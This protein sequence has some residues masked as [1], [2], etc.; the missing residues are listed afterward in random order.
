MA[1]W[2]HSVGLVQHGLQGDSPECRISGRRHAD[3][4][5]RFPLR[6][7]YP[8]ANRTGPVMGWISRRVAGFLTFVVVSGILGGYAA[9]RGWISGE[10][11]LT[12]AAGAVILG[13]AFLT[14]LAVTSHMKRSDEARKAW[15]EN[16]RAWHE[17]YARMY[18]GYVRRR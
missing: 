16:Q 17:Y 14:S 15:E 10:P 9:V 12:T 4:R 18:P 2:E 8:S 6:N 5:D 7:A 11:S 3:S 1:V 13:I